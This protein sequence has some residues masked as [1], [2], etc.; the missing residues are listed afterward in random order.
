M[1]HG[2]I[3]GIV[4]GQ[5]FPNRAALMQAGVHRASQ[6]GI[7]GYGNDQPAESIV[8]SHGYKDDVDDGDEVIYTGQGGRDPETGGQIADQAFATGNLGLAR[9]YEQGVPV[10]VSRRVPNGYRYDGLYRVERH[11]H[12]TGADGF[13]IY[14]YR[15]I[16]VEGEVHQL[17][18]VAPLGNSTPAR[19]AQTT[20][21]VVRDTAVARA[22]KLMHE[23][24]CQ[25][26][27]ETLTLPGGRYSEAAH[28]W[29]LGRPHNGP[30]TPDNIL[31]LCPNHHVLLDGG[32]I[33]IDAHNVVQPLGTPL[34]TSS[35][36]VISKANTDYHRT[37]IYPA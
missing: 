5:V 33:W 1:P 22:V 34:R 10:R 20:L 21:R 26:C 7:A 12:E 25:V 15:L 32:G 4:P 9:C 24:R 13:R 28:I 18:V 23:H 8:L 29:P 27:G 36:H 6:A 14:R 11:W 31:C 19:V 37:R 30:D 35:L 17:P 2:H 3:T 16:A